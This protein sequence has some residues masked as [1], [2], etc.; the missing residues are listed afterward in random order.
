MTNPPPKF[1]RPPARRTVAVMLGIV[2]GLSRLTA[3]EWPVLQLD[4]GGHI[5]LPPSVLT[6]LH[7]ATIETWVKWDNLTGWQRFFSYGTLGKDAYIGVNRGSGDLQFVVR[8]R[9]A[10]F[11]PLNVGGLLGENEWCHVAA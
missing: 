10:G 7:N 9:F 3:A 6:N 2:L 8:D 5:E 4:G 1:L 11:S